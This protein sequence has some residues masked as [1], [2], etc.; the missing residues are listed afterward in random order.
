MKP[1]IQAEKSDIMKV[2]KELREPFQLPFHPCGWA[3]CCR[4]YISVEHAVETAA[5][6]QFHLE[7]PPPPRAAQDGRVAPAQSCTTLSAQ[8]QI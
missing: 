7:L 8:A 6:L 2:S 3:A 5:G 4:Q 1:Q